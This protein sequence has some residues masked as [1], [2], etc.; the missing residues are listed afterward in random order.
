MRKEKGPELTPGPQ[1][2]FLFSEGMIPVIDESLN[3]TKGT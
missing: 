3:P 1:N 2:S